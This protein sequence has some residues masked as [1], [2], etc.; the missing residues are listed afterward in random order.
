MYIAPLCKDCNQILTFFPTLA[1]ILNPH[2]LPIVMKYRFVFYLILFSSTALLAQNKYDYNLFMNEAREYSLLF[3]GELPMRFGHWI[4]KDG[5][6]F[7]AFSNNYEKGS[8]RFR[9]RWYQDNILLNLNAFID[10]LYVLDSKGSPAVVNKNFVDSFSMG[11][12]Q[13]VRYEKDDAILKSGYYQ[14]CYTGRHKLIKKIH[15]IYY[16]KAG[17]DGRLQRGFTLL[18]D[19][20]LWK[21]GQWNRIKTKK[22]INKLFPEQKKIIKN[23]SKHIDYKNN[24]ENALVEILN[25]LDH[26]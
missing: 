26:I 7:F 3:R 16:Q 9:G 19:Y 20:Y 18:E 11:T 13:F 22:D 25:Y 21:N 5:S 2:L 17:N 12:R 1:K 10:E 8:V 23:V 15:K 4:P 24:K 14:I 6:T